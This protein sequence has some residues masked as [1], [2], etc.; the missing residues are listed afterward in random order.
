[1][2]PDRQIMILDYYEE[3]R[4]T[5][6]LMLEAARKSDWQ[7]LVEEERRCAT[8][9][10]RLQACGDESALLDA[11]AK[12]RAHQ[13]IC[14]ILAND[15]EIRNLAQPWLRQLE[16]HMGASKMSRKVAAAYRR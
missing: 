1:M 3:V 10:G 7:A 15:A 6:E 12:K 13:I 5:S 8:V 9:V 14:A 16:V 2:K 4:E 11:P